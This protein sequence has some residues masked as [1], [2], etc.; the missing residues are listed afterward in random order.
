[1]DKN[2]IDLTIEQDAV[3]DLIE[4]FSKTIN[5]LTYKVSLW[6]EF[7]DNEYSYQIEF[8][9]LQIKY[10]KKYKRE[11]IKVWNQLKKEIDKDE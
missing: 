7:E 10:L 2:L 5:N 9:S 1:M 11:L 3:G 8:R 4:M 6:K